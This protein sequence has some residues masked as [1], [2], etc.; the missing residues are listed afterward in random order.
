MD[1]NQRKLTKSEWESIEI[2]VSAKEMEVLK[3]IVESYSNV[4]LKQNKNNSLFTFLKIEFSVKMEEYLY[5][6][7]FLDKMNALVK[8]Y[9]IDYVTVDVKP[10]ITISKADQIRLNK[11]EMNASNNIYEFVLMEHVEK[12][13]Q[14]K[15]QKK[16]KWMFHYFTLYKLTK[17]NISKLNKFVKSVCEQ[18][19][20]K[21]ADDVDL[22]H[23]ISN[24]VHYIEK[25]DNLL[26][27]N[28]MML[29]DHQKNIFTA[30]KEK[31][32][33]LILYIAPTGTGK[34]LTP[35]GLSEQ[36]KIIFVCAARHVGLALARAAIS[37]H[38]KIAFAFGCSSAEDV[39]LHYFAAKEFTVDR[40]S[41]G[42]RKVDNSVG[43]KVEIII[44]DIQSYLYA[45]Y[46]MLAFN[47][48]E[49]MV[50]YWDEPT[51]SLDYE[52]HNFHSIIKK[53][54]SDNLIPNLVLSSATLP[55]LHEITETIHDFKTKFTDANIINIV[56][57]DCRK[58]IPLINNSG[59]VVMPHSLSD[60]YEEVGRIVE[61]CLDHLTLLR[62]FDLQETAEFICFCEEN[63]FVQRSARL[64]RSFASIDD[65]N[66]QSVKLHYL[67][68]I[69]NIQPDVW[70]T[71][72]STLKMKRQ[73]RIIPNNQIDPTGNAITKVRSIG[74]GVT[75]HNNSAPVPFGRT[76]SQH[77]DVKPNTNAIVEGQSAIFVTTK[78]AFTLTDGP[79]IF[80][81]SD[82]TK[83][84]KFCIQ[85]AN[86]PA[87]VMN[88]IIEKIEYNNKINEKIAELEKT[89]EDEIE[90][91]ASK[92]SNAPSTTNKDKKNNA[93]KSDD[94]LGKTKDKAII[95]LQNQIDMLRT[96]IK[97]ASL[98]EIFIPNKP[99]HLKKWAPNLPIHNAFTSD[100]DEDTI[101]SIMLLQ[102]VED[103]W[104]ILLLLGVGVF[105]THKSIEYTEIMKKL[106]D[107]Q[108]LYL[109]IADSDYIY[110]TNYQFCH[111]YLSKD[112][113]L[114]QEKI[115]QGMGRI[116][117]NNIQ[118]E[119]SVRF[120]D[121]EQIQILFRTFK[122]EE[123]PEVLNMNM[124]F[125]SKHIK[126]D[127]EE[128]KYLH[129]SS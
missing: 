62:Y 60:N 24:S 64:N 94:K 35:L 28:D 101:I 66:M 114:T 22:L 93:K 40:R 124:L 113:H 20:D 84:A 39:R 25:N 85:Q 50:T 105:T 36:K 15:N 125:N 99:S 29:Y 37:I 75:V 32:S 100:I 65:V 31:H 107:N 48:A 53:N 77:P 110:G 89:M 67:K 5:V 80:L 10:K 112:L 30:I 82:V 83:I 87:P 7:Y 1:L 69:K 98:N 55:K 19:L 41:G 54:W 52:S 34:T 103:S 90:K 57:H 8:Q 51:I 128:K 58:T 33:K 78:D 27:Y 96:M 2:P 42:I 92:A 95:D 3:L 106:A 63:N 104:K 123:K 71:I 45:M 120:R 102:N 117:R 49:N 88:D 116:G 4:N 119:Y 129:L 72:Y 18:I 17:N 59:Y 44:C 109:I 127:S 91:T 56:S 81:A 115:I 97:Q 11:V 111:G 13:L 21:Y 68:V 47:N 118:Q 61:H 122:P 73:Q 43:D 76:L 12:M 46:Y 74:P 16:E 14:Y 70:K 9:K 6:K 26:K 86:I 108:K 121:D 79:A 23:V 38:K 126:W